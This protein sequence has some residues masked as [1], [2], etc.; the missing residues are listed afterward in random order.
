MILCEVGGVV[1][2]GRVHAGEACGG[3]WL[4]VVH[5]LHLGLV[6]CI[7]CG[8]DWIGCEYRYMDRLKQSVEESFE[9]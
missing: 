3:V 1:I 5:V 9:G 8:L 6:A 7:V 4:R 2:G